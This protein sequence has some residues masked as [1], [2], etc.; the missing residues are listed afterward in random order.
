MIIYK[1]ICKVNNKI[2]IGQTG[3]TL[4]QRFNRHMGYQK[5]NND[6]IKELQRYHNVTTDC[7]VIARCKGKTKSPY[8]GYNFK[9]YEDY[10]EGQSTIESIAKEK[11]FSE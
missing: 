3:E 4:K 6:T 5:D 9:Y 11:Y 2:Y 8:K 1:I 7:M 10:I